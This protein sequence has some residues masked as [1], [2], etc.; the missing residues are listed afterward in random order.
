[1]TCASLELRR[2]P[3]QFPET[4]E[5]GGTLPIKR[6][7]SSCRQAQDAILETVCK[8]SC[9]IK[10]G[11]PRQ[12]PKLSTPPRRVRAQETLDRA[13]VLA[14]LGT[15]PQRYDPSASTSHHTRDQFFHFMHSAPSHLY[16]RK[17]F[18]LPHQVETT[19]RASNKLSIFSHPLSYCRE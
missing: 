10:S 8:I 12:R 18:F 11:A 4:E 6:A 13:E 15:H 9:G 16:N 17:N 19:L 2:V 5:T 14:L 7:L 3:P 1:M